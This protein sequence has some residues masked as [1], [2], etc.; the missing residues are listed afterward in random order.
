MT[1]GQNACIIAN[2]I[3]SEAVGYPSKKVPFLCRRR[4][5]DFQGEFPVPKNLRK[6]RL[7]PG[8]RAYFPF[9]GLGGCPCCFLW[10]CFFCCFCGSV[11]VVIFSFDSLLLFCVCVR[12]VFFCPLSL[13][14]SLLSLSLSLSLSIYLSIY[15]YIYIYVSLSLS[16]FLSFAFFILTSANPS[17]LWGE[18]RAGVL[19]CRFFVLCFPF[20]II[21][22]SL[23]RGLGFGCHQQRTK[24]SQG[25]PRSITQQCCTGIEM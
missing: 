8:P 17:I 1:W 23:G 12:V 22:D 2:D 21:C 11:V 16:L 5:E 15:L 9:K 24:R 13:S 25:P 6:S 19:W 20:F 14:L 7:I 10:G 4:V 18:F 3:E